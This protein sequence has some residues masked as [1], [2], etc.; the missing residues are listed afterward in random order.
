MLKKYS[1]GLVSAVFEIEIRARDTEVS[2]GQVAVFKACHPDPERSRRG[3]TY[4]FVS[5]IQRSFASL[6]MTIQ[7]Y[8]SRYATATFEVR[9]CRYSRR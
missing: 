8:V 1:M 7:I 4:A 5:A 9:N 6:K 3:R 2:D